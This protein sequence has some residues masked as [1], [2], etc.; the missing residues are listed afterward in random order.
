MECNNHLDW[1]VELKETQGS[2]EVSAISKVKDII[3]FGE[4]KISSTEEMPLLLIGDAINLKIHRFDAV[5]PEYSLD[6]LRDLESKLVLITGKH[7]AEKAKTEKF[8]NVCMYVC[9]CVC[10]CVSLSTV[11][12]NSRDRYEKLWLL[13]FSHF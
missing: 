3:Q 2:F 12:L 8:Q 11:V 7:T 10:V 5:K 6:D 9:V 1:F 4:Y 13:E